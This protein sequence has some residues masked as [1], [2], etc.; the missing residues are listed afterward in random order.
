M[1]L[2]IDTCVF[3]L[4]FSDDSDFSPIYNWITQRNGKIIIGGDLTPKNRAI[5]RM[6]FPLNLG[7]RR[8]QDEEETFYRRA[9]YR[10]AESA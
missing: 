3:H 6:R 10:C 7:N 9:N 2:V 8:S 1:C 4:V 5:V